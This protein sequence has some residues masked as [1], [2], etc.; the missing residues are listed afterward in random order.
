MG[1]LL[2][3][4]VIER[5]SWRRVLPEPPEFGF[6]LSFLYGFPNA[7]R[8]RLFRSSSSVKGLR[9]GALVMAICQ[10][11]KA[12]A[13]A[14]ETQARESAGSGK[15]SGPWEGTCGE[16][17]RERKDV[18]EVHGKDG[19][20]TGG[21]QGRERCHEIGFQREN[22]AGFGSFFCRAHG[23]SREASVEGGSR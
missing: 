3:P 5:I 16:M 15:R 11:K 4:S 18:R 21:G 19:T 23:I 14:T 1:S 8:C 6:R 17:G 20:S 22:S 13:R 9:G 2:C 7:T 12:R 10:G